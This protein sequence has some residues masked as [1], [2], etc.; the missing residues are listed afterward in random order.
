MKVT[1]SRKIAGKREKVKVKKKKKKI[2]VAVPLHLVG[3]MLVV[4]GDQMSLVE[5]EDSRV[6][7]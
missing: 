2:R 6:C 3:P 7:W 1:G 4:L 5:G